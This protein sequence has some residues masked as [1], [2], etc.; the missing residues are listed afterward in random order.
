MSNSVPAHTSKV[1][2]YRD[3]RHFT[4]MWGPKSQSFGNLSQVTERSYLVAVSNRAPLVKSDGIR[5]TTYHRKVGRIDSLA[6][7]RVVTDSHKYESET[8]IGF[9]GAT[10][11][12]SPHGSFY[13]DPGTTVPAWMSDKVIQDCISELNDVRALLIEDFFQAK[14]T[15]DTAVSIFNTIVKL[16]MLA[17]R[18]QWRKLRR[19]LRSLGHEPSRKMA[20]SWLMYYY[21]IRPLVST[22]GAVLESYNG[23]V[24]LAEA[25]RK[26]SNPVDPAGFVVGYG[27]TV[28]NGPAAQHVRCGLSVAIA[29]D[30]TM[31]T[32]NAFGVTGNGIDAAV[33][34]WA[35]TPYSFVVDW[36]LP[37]ERW[38]STRRWSSGIKYQT[39]YVTRVLTCDATAVVTNPMTGGNDRG[40]LPK[41]RVRCMQ[42]SRTAY[43]SFTPPSGL[44]LDWSLTP[45]NLVS[46]AALII[47]RR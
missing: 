3:T 17:W 32:W 23:K 42:F 44:N 21:G 45:T 19:M 40:T 8:S 46:A 27:G 16:F 11:R 29:M 41:V 10:L 1:G 28:V 43:N 30:S 36:L 9:R 37:V 47:Q 25:K 4:Y 12:E 39:G 34:L 35:I 15:L 2:Y 7:P 14:Q 33:A 13:S 26:L 24:R 38:L 31:R 22:M 5:A 18:K 20:N 6:S